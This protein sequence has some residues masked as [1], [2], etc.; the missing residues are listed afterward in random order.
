MLAACAISRCD[1][2]KEPIVGG[3]ELPAVRGTA[4]SSALHRDIVADLDFD[5]LVVHFANK[6]PGRMALPYIFLD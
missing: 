5:K 2:R 4:G 3:V 1:A 6:N